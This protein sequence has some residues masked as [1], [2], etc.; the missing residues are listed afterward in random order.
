MPSSATQKQFQPEA[1]APE[2]T[3]HLVVRLK[4]SD[5]EAAKKRFAPKLGGAHV[6]GEIRRLAVD[7]YGVEA[8]DLFQLQMADVHGMPTP[9][10]LSASCNE[11]GLDVRYEECKLSRL[12]P[13]DFPCVFLL[14]D[15]SGYLASRL[16][17]DLQFEI[18]LAGTRRAMGKAELQEQYSGVLLRIQPRDERG[19]ETGADEPETP[20]ESPAPQSVI[21]S[22]I[23]YTFRHNKALLWQ[24]SLAAGL[25]NI[26]LVLLPLFIMAVYDRVIPHL[27][28]ETLWALSIGVGIALMLDLAVRV[29]RLKLLDAIGLSTSNALQARLFR[30]LTRLQLK[31]APR[32]A[33]GWLLRLASLTP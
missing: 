9:E 19:V 15:G 10:V 4:S 22:V 29:V 3:D 23:D 16:R 6:L 27:A 25:S 17:E 8:G 26:F 33:G 11:V 12:K 32:S 30:R 14:K 7:W 18:D 24:L 21:Q 28:M 31:D 2:S 1:E 5:G 20:L 13:K